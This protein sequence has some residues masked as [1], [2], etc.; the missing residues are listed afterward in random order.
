MIEVRGK[1]ILKVLKAN[2]YLQVNTYVKIVFKNIDNK[3][4]APRWLSQIS[5]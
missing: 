3:M 1:D 4:R 2:N 5:I